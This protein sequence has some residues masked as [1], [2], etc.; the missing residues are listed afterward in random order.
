M[1][2]FLNMVFKRFCADALTRFE[3][4]GIIC[5]KTTIPSNRIRGTKTIRT[6]SAP[7]YAPSTRFTNSAIAS[8]CT[9]GRKALITATSK[10]Y[11]VWKGIIFI[12]SRRNTK[13]LYFVFF[14]LFILVFPSLHSL[15]FFDYFVPTGTTGPG[16]IPLIR[17]VLSAHLND[18]FL[19]LGI[20]DIS[21]HL[22]F[23]QSAST[24]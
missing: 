16:I 3:T 15:L 24:Q 21:L 10:R 20:R 14:R 23:S 18:I 7:P 9:V 12:I 8:A 1:N 22:E 13:R 17:N 2:R 5:L 19:L 11:P 6:P 4:D